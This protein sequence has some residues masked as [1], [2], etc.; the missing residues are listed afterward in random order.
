MDARASPDPACSNPAPVGRGGD[1]SVQDDT[2]RALR[3]VT[4]GQDESGVMNES[5][6]LVPIGVS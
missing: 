5:I 2:R 1:D 3:T 6:Q 4:L